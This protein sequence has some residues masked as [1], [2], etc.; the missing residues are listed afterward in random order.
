MGRSFAGTEEALK[1][2]CACEEKREGSGERREEAVEGKRGGVGKWKSGGEDG[3][4]AREGSGVEN[5][6]V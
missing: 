4:G 3:F 2:S 1:R 6:A 5:L